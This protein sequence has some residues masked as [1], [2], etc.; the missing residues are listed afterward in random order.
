MFPVGT[1]GAAGGAPS[2]IAS[3]EA[4]LV[5]QLL[6]AVTVIFPDVV[7]KV[8]VIEVPV[9]AVITAPAGTVQV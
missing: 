1:A 7:P 8:T 2:V 5:P 9:L 3:V 4:P 6:E